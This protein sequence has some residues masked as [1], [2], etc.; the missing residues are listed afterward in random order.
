MFSFSPMNLSTSVVVP[1]DSWKENCN[2]HEKNIATSI[3]LVSVTIYFY[4]EQMSK[5]LITELLCFLD[6]QQKVGI[7]FFCISWIFNK[8]LVLF[9]FVFPAY[10]TKSCYYFFYH[11]SFVWQI[12]PVWTGSFGHKFHPLGDEGALFFAYVVLKHQWLFSHFSLKVTDWR[13]LVA[14]D[15]NLKVV[16]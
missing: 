4:F 9:F 8:K 3:W 7:I 14:L 2:P 16:F 10:S 15:R 11:D 1:S 12:F 5:V 13:S 6:I